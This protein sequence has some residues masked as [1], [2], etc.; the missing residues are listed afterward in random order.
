MVQ[1]WSSFPAD[2]QKRVTKLLNIANLVTTPSKL[3]KDNFSIWREDIV[4]LPNAIDV[5]EYSYKLREN[6]APHLGW[7]RKFEWHYNPLLAIETLNILN[8]NFSNISLIMGGADFNDGSAKKVR[9]VASKYKLLNR[10]E[11]TGFVPRIW[12]NS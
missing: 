9:S 11:F 2:G 7:L 10:L 8:E 6:P 5:N 12:Q 3:F 1:E 4:Y